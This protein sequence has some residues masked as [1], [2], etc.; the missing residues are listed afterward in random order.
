MTKKRN[1]EADPLSVPNPA[2]LSFHRHE[3]R[4]SPC[5]GGV[6]VDGIGPEGEGHG[7]QEGSS[8]DTIEQLP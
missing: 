8:V 7:G 2:N 6:M 3:Y 1:W 5:D 4:G